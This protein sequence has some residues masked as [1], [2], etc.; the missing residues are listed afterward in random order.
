MENMN[1]EEIELYKQK[2]LKAYHLKK[3]DIDFAGDEMEEAWIEEELNTFR[4]EIKSCSARILE[5]KE[6]KE[7][8]V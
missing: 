1:I 4:V 8:I 6:E 7:S 5:L 2:L 3:E